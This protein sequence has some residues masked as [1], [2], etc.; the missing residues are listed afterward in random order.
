MANSLHAEVSMIFAFLL[1]GFLGPCSLQKFWIGNN[2]L[3]WH[4]APLHAH[5]MNTDCGNTTAPVPTLGPLPIP[6][7]PLTQKLNSNATVVVTDSFLPGHRLTSTVRRVPG[8]GAWATCWSG[9]TC[10]R[11]ASARV[12]YP[13]FPW[14]HCLPYSHAH[15]FTH[16]H[17][18]TRTHPL[19][20]RLIFAF[21][22]TSPYFFPGQPMRC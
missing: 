2:G 17:A 10:W 3:P 12:P 19:P 13:L 5:V 22:R 7:R 18:H 4:M 15:T 1:V 20:D 14:A 6:N 9:R 11:C 16:T 21:F 8:G